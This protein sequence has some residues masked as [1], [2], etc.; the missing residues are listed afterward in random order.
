MPLSPETENLITFYTDQNESLQKQLDQL[1]S[2]ENGITITTGIDTTGQLIQ[3]KIWGANEVLDNYSVPI[4]NIDDQIVTIND[5][6]TSLRQ[7]IIT[8]YNTAVAY[9][10]SHVGGPGIGS[11]ATL[12][13]EEHTSE[14]QSH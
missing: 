14:L 11:T 13:S 4:S 5:E 6:I 7:Q 12:R 2:V 1:E 3:T 8:T 10:C 9:G